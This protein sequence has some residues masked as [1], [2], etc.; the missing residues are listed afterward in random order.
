MARLPLD[1]ARL[2]GTRPG[3][4]DGNKQYY[5]VRHMSRPDP[6]ALPFVRRR[7]PTDASLAEIRS[8]KM[9]QRC[10]LFLRCRRPG[11]KRIRLPRVLEHGAPIG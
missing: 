10:V 8:S 9:L 7:P 4:S 1:K 2:H 6:N 11:K 3:A 5:D